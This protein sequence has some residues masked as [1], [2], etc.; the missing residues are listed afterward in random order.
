MNTAALFCMALV[1]SLWAVLLRAA[2]PPARQAA[3][4]KQ[5]SLRTC[6]PFRSVTGRLSAWTAIT[7]THDNQVIAGLCRDSEPAYLAHFDDSSRTFACRAVRGCG[8]PR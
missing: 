3:R 7:A 4:L 6:S 2:R 1:T 8:H 5:R